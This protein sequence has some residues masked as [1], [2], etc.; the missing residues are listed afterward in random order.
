MENASVVLAQPV[1]P[2]PPP[3]ASEPSQRSALPVIAAQVD[4]EAQ[5]GAEPCHAN[6]CPAVPLPKRFV[7]NVLVAW[8]VGTADAPVPFT[9]TAFAFAAARLMLDAAPKAL[10][11]VQDKRPVQV[12]EV[13]ATLESALVPFPYRSCELVK[14]VCPVHSG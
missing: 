10:N 11:P 14:V 6:T 5:M 9:K 2:P 12:I 3:V 4:V 7:P 1:P 8:N 13:V